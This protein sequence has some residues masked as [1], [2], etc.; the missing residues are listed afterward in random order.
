M[1]KN[2]KSD[3]NKPATDMEAC[4]KTQSQKRKAFIEI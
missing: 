1:I 2:I 4:I 3:N